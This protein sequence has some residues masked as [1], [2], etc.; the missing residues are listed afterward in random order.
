MYADLSM[1]QSEDDLDISGVR[2][3]RQR[4][5]RPSL[6]HKIVSTKKARKSSTVS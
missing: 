1:T 6:E 4:G 2:T 3:R 5:K